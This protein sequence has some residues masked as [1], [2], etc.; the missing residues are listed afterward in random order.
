MD[1]LISHGP[2]ILVLAC[3]FGFF[4][5]CGMGA[6]D[7]SNA[8]GTSV[9]AKVLTIK[10][11]VLIAMVFEFAGAYLA[12]G[13]VTATI[14]SGIT[15]S[16]CFADTP[17]LLVYGM[18]STLL[19]TALWLVLASS[20]GWPVSTTHTVVGA[21][22]GF[23]AVGVGFD[24][25]QWDRLGNIVV[26]W[27]AS[28]LLAGLV[29]YALFRSVQ[30]L[31]LDTNDPF[32]QAKRFIPIYIFI[33][34]FMIT[35]VTFTKGLK[36][37]GMDLSA[38][39]AVLLSVLCG[40]MVATI[41]YLLMRRIKAPEVVNRRNRYESVERLFAILMIFTAC[42]IAFAHGSNDVSNAVG[43]LAAIY[44]VVSEGGSITGQTNIPSWI[45]LLGAT[46]IVIGLALFG[47]KVMRTIGEKITELT[48]SRGFAAELGAASTVVM[49]SG[50]G[51]PLST[52]HTLVGAVLGV[53][54]ARGI[55]ALN[56]RVIGTIFT[57]WV[58]TLPAGALLSILFFYFFKGLFGG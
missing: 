46:G 9:G 18:M 16:A 40:L 49:A 7:V 45:L 58:I 8:M 55:A 57:S 56:L 4:M 33:T 6:N 23:A 47:Y 10:Q 15:D 5:A 42:A 22:G 41:G 17:H 31:I 36:H 25:V 24:S 13:S 34:G 12:G 54:M 53:C 26:S 11:A 37:V 27:I 35:M 50:L 39:T 14:R 20:M 48:P 28:P 52:T 29:S 38:T 30:R 3:V 44:S 1:I 32:T 2:I 51:V 19:A 43:P 21:I